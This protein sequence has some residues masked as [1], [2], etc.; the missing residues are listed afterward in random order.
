M[1]SRRQFGQ[2]SLVTAGVAFSPTLPQ[3]KAPTEE[4]LLKAMTAPVLHLEKLSDPVLIRSMELL[5]NRKDFLVRIRSKDGAEAVTVPN[6]SR[7]RD[8][9]PIFLNR[10]APFFVGK[11]ARQLE[12]LL[13]GVYRSKSNYKWQGLA[14]WCSVAAA[15]MAVLEL[16]GRVSGQSVGQLF[17]RQSNRRRIIEALER[18][19]RT[20]E[21]RYYLQEEIPEIYSRA[22][23]V[24]NIPVGHDLN[25][26]FFEALSC[27]ALLLTERAANGQE[28]LFKEDVHYVGFDSDKELFEKTDY[29]LRND[30]ER[31]KIAS[32]GYEEVRARHSLELRLQTL[33][34]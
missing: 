16:L 4:A 13:E 14:F 31:K 29:Y 20:N 32:A 5:R 3:A 11:D 24:V 34:V 26:R 7:L 22:K 2:H 10:V 25:F 19:Y 33:L 28:E 6:S 9:Y 18:Q 15:E 23:I 1:I 17:G 8:T 30:V 27:G 12:A 21:Q